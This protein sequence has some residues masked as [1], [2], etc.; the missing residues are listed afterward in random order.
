ME[1]LSC[2]LLLLTASAEPD[3]LWVTDFSEMPYG[4][5]A[6]LHWSSSASM[7]LFLNSNVQRVFDFDHSSLNSDYYRSMPDTDSLVL[8]VDYVW[9]GWGAY[10]GG[11]VRD[12]AYSRS[13]INVHFGNTFDTLWDSIAGYLWFDSSLSGNSVT[14]SESGPYSSTSQGTL[15]LR[16]PDIP[17][18]QMFR[19]EFRGDTGCFQDPSRKG[20]Q[21][22][23]LEWD[24]ESAV[25]LSYRSDQQD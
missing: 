15:T 5:E 25:L 22:A 17:D 10:S 6:D 23:Y 20:G 13:R 8:V 3:T 4:W 12:G 21:Y 24:L 9:T 2:L 19:I 7:R 14:H 11:D 16:L 18:W 1:I